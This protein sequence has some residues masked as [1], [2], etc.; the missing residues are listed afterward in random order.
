MGNEKKK[1]LACLLL[2]VCYRVE[3]GPGG[4]GRC[5]ADTLV[6]ATGYKK[7]MGLIMKFVL[8]YKYVLTKR[9]PM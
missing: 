7:D 4:F 3:K 9:T 8:C 1:T 6:A 5:R 2:E